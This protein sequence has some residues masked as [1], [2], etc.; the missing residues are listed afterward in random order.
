MHSKEGR[1]ESKIAFRALV[2]SQPAIEHGPL[3][4]DRQTITGRSPSRHCNHGLLTVEERRP[5]VLS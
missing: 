5:S 1:Q 2:R 4:T 3:P